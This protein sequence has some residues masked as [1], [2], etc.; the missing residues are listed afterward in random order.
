MC[1]IIASPNGS[2]PKQE[3][4]DRS[5]QQNPDGFGLVYAVAGRLRISKGLDAEHY[6]AT[7]DW[8]RT[9]HVPYILHTRWSTHGK[10]SLENCHPFRVS[11]GLAMAHNGVLTK[12]PIKNP[13]LSDTW[14]FVQRLKSVGINCQSVTPEFMKVLGSDIGKS[15]KLAFLT[16]DGNIFL[17]NEEQGTWDDDLWY[18]NDFA[19]WNDFDYAAWSA[20]CTSTA[21]KA[22]KGFTSGINDPSKCEICF[23]DEIEHYSE[24]LLMCN[25]RFNWAGKTKGGS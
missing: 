23:R 17:C 20:P 24:G 15:N 14:H 7:C 25:D 11:R 2:V 3:I 19:F 10:V 6:R 1:L 5:F 18:S 4:L 22:G 13:R 16:K 21:F 9:A 12:E 8:L